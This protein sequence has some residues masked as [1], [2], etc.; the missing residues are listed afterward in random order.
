MYKKWCI[1]KIES[2]GEWPN[3]ISK[4]DFFLKKKTVRDLK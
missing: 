3:H 1:I 2:A 4:L